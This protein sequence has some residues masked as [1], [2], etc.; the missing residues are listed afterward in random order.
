MKLIYWLLQEF[1]IGTNPKFCIKT[2]GLYL[3]V[4]NCMAESRKIPY[5]LHPTLAA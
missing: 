3:A 1:Y 5:L 4:A 2:T